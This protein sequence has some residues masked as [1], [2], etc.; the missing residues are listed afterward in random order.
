MSMGSSGSGSGFLASSNLSSIAAE[1]ID[2][3]F[4]KVIDKKF[5]HL[6]I[7]PPTAVH[8]PVTRRG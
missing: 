2:V 1:K 4:G 5:H 7:P 3:F 8:K 6:Q